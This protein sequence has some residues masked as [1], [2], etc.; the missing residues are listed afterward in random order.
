MVE[1]IVICLATWLAHT[2]FIV[3]ASGLAE[4]SVAV[5]ILVIIIVSKTSGYAVPHH[6]EAAIDELGSNSK[7]SSVHCPLPPSRLIDAS[8]SYSSSTRYS[9]NRNDSWWSSSLTTSR[10]CQPANDL[11]QIG[12]PHTRQQND[13]D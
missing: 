1:I 6:P 8:P 12:S 5:I 7:P 3:S 13:L 9:L 11:H 10:L 2:I 4:D